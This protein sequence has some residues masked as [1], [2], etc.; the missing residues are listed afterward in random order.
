MRA[1]RFTIR[2]LFA[3]PSWIFLGAYRDERLRPQDKPSVGLKQ[4]HAPEYFISDRSTFTISELEVELTKPTAARF[5]TAP[6]L[7]ETLERAL[8]CFL[9]H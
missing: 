2:P 1:R 7:V 9:D 4:G 5:D 8:L 6:V 3:L